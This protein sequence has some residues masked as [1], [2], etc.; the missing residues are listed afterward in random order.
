V[1][2][3]R[4][5]GPFEKGEGVESPGWRADESYLQRVKSL[6]C[7]SGAGIEED[8]DRPDIHEAHVH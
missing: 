2:E 3:G 6:L 8:G 1:C 7:R 5:N 4:R